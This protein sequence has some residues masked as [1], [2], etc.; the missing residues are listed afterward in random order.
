MPNRTIHDPSRISS[1]VQPWL[2]HTPQPDIPPDQPTQPDVPPV[3]DPP[4]QPGEV[5]RSVRRAARSSAH[6]AMHSTDN[7]ALTRWAR[8]VAWTI[9]ARASVRVQAGLPPQAKQFPA[10]AGF[11]ERVAR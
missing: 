10:A 6:S 5:P 9:G 8:W 2:A 7:A 4:P 1:G 3:G 11:C